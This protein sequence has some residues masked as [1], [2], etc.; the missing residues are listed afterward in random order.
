MAAFTDQ[1]VDR[2]NEKSIIQ[3]RLASI[4]DQDTTSREIFQ[5][6]GMFGIGKT[7][8]L[9][10]LDEIVDQADGKFEHA[11]ISLAEFS[12][13]P[14]FLYIILKLL[15]QLNGPDFESGRVRAAIQEYQEYAVQFSSAFPQLEDR[16]SFIDPRLHKVEREFEDFL[17]AILKHKPVVLL[18]DGTERFT[19]ASEGRSIAQWVEKLY[20]NTQIDKQLTIVLGS[21][22]DKTPWTTRNGNVRAA[23]PDELRLFNPDETIEHWNRISQGTPYATNAIADFVHKNTLGHPYSNECL[24][25]KLKEFLAH[26]ASAELSNRTGQALVPDWPLVFREAT[27]SILEEWIRGFPEI[28]S[29]K[30]L[31]RAI[32]PLRDFHRDIAK[33]CL[34]GYILIL[35]KH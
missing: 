21:R 26:G 17:H 23:D 8:L 32:A 20:I 5:F 7:A 24:G 13:P 28:E 19:Q 9:Q 14:H 35:Q 29:L 34:M 4:F 22:S 27:E 2:N 1:L 25:N 16:K 12:Q 33:K 11:Y 15:D 31:V 6:Y 30:S 3:R 10:A 18:F